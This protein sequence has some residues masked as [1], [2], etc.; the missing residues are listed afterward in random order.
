[1]PAT[2][3]VEDDYLL[4]AQSL[5][6]VRGERSLF[7][8]L[9]FKLKE[10]Q[11]LH[12]LGAN[13]SGKTSLLRILSG[14][15]DPTDGSVLWQQKTIHNHP[16]F[17]QQ[18]AFLGHKDG[19]KN[20]LTALENL[21]FYQRLEGIIND[22][23]VDQHLAQMGILDCADLSANKLSFGQR[24]RLAFARLLMPL[25]KLWILDEPFTGI[26]VQGRVLI[27]GVCLKHLQSGG[28]IVLTN[29]QSLRSSSLSEQLIEL[30]L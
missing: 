5:S 7:Q 15:T 12:V 10:G 8:S 24:R 6:C 9:N 22:D 27:E 25:F 21:S 26:D 29:H 23:L 14:L 2:N 4:S 11:C 19:I 3:H 13:G 1:M 28:M 17:L 16:R 18:S 30:E 20:Q